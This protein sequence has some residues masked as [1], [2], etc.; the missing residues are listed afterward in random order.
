MKK[1]PQNG[2][3]HE[4]RD[5]TAFKEKLFE[6]I[7]NIRGGTDIRKVGAHKRNSMISAHDAY[8]RRHKQFIFYQTYKIKLDKVTSEGENVNT[9][10][11]LN[12]TNRRIFDH[13]EVGVEYDE[14]VNEIDTRLG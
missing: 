8:L 6:R 4:Y 9:T 11:Y 5:K 1:N 13:S 3:D 2:R 14:S 7:Y 10:A 12:S